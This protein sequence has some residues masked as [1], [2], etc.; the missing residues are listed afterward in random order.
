MNSKLALLLIFV[1]SLS[2]SCS[3]LLDLS[4]ENSLT[5][6]NGLVSNA[7]FESVLRGAGQLLRDEVREV[8]IL[9]PLKGEFADAY[10]PGLLLERQLSPDFVPSSSWS[11]HYALIAQANVVLK[12]IDRAEFSQEW[13]NIYKG[14]ALFYKAIAYFEL[15]RQ[16]GDCILVQDEVELEP[17]AKTPWT[18]VADYAIALAEESADL[19][20]LH[21]N[22]RNF[23]GT[24]I[25]RSSPSSGA[26]FALLAHLCAWKAGCRY[27][28]NENYDEQ[29][30][31]EKALD[32]AN[33]LI[34]SGEY[35][36]ATNPQAVVDF[37]L[38]GNT[39]ESIFE[40][41]FRNLWQEISPVL[42]GAPYLVSSYY[43]HYPVK[44]QS[45]PAEQA[46]LRI[47]YQAINNMF[48]DGDLRKNA[49][50][51]DFEKWSQPQHTPITQGNSYPN[52][53][54]QII[55]ATDGWFSGQMLNFNVDK[56]WWRFADIVLLR[57]EIRQRLGDIGGAIAD[58]NTVRERANAPLY[59][60]S[61]H[62][63]DLR[64]TIF[65]EREK[66]LLM[67][68]HRYYD[69]I[70]NGYAASELE[71]GF[72]AAT[73]QDFKDGAFFL[74]IMRTGTPN[75]FDNNPL[76]EQNKYWSKF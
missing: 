52:K 13:K 73:V 6:R 11:V 41:P 33:A 16:F 45:S 30:Y 50:F 39:S 53:Y 62:G 1:F 43:Q 4:P 38:V 10:E 5:Y 63:G 51:F 59:D 35:K 17:K 60:P 57:A 56:I 70:R 18:A 36:L 14:Q 58:L 67:E 34:R 55:V 12:Y 15:I 26:A 48:A 20:P 65:K 3:K 29:V 69:V 32:A 61:E 44:P 71:G 8:H 49:W 46:T 25:T 19:L 9:Q 54:T 72:K 64:Y 22:L 7:D 37:V 76:L 28:A 66:E 2:V 21:N 27:F 68:G 47:T 74:A 40:T 75:D 24:A 31:W 23:D 42:R